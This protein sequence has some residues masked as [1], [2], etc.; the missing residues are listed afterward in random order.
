[1]IAFA[2]TDTGIAI[3]KV[4]PA[5]PGAGMKL[6]LLLPVEVAP[7][8]LAVNSDFDEGRLLARRILLSINELGMP[9]ATEILNPTTPQAFADLISWGAIGART[10]ES[11]THREIA[12]GLPFPVGFKNGTSGNRYR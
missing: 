5:G 1:M 2:V 12:S 3:A 7:D 11:Q 9:A 6:A 10:T 4:T 8:V